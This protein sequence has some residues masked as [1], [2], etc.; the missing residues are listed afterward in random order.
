MPLADPQGLKFMSIL[1]QALSRGGDFTDYY[2]R[3]HAR[4]EKKTPT[5]YVKRNSEGLWDSYTRK[6]W[7][8]KKR[9]TVGSKTPYE[10]KK[11][12]KKKLEMLK[13]IRWGNQKAHKRLRA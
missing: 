9:F 8:K 3:L 6:G 11:R 7:Y 5:I 4:D 13:Q 12:H 10:A 1:S 2:R